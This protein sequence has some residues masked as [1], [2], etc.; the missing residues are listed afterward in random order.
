MA[1]RRTEVGRGGHPRHGHGG[2]REQHYGDRLGLYETLTDE[3]GQVYYKTWDEHDHHSIVLDRAGLDYVAYKVY[4][5][6]T[7]T[8]LEG[9][10]KAPA[11]ERVNTGVL[12]RAAGAS[13]S[14]C[15]AGTRCSSTRR[16]SRS[17]TPWVPAIPV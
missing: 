4:D 10:I 11:V 16:R 2:H 13:A 5:D 1:T 3:K 12:R 6:A 15:R 14:C 8:D 9:K 17:A 7:L